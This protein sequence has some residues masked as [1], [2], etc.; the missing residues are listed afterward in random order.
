MQAQ[1]NL[2]VKSHILNTHLSTLK[3]LKLTPVT[4]VFIY[5]NMVL[6]KVLMTL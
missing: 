2:N 5:S 3:N 1:K 6:N 4:H